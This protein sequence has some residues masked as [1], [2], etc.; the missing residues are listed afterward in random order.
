MTCSGCGS[1]VVACPRR[2]SAVRF[3]FAGI[4]APW[5]LTAAGSDGVFALAYNRGQR[6]GP[7][8]KRPAADMLARLYAMALGG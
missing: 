7:V 8:A 3:A 4:P 6:P 5:W 1:C 2:T